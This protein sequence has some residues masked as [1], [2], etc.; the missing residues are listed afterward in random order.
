MMEKN[1]EIMMNCLRS[2]KPLS[3]FYHRAKKS[4]TDFIK[5]PII[6]KLMKLINDLSQMKKTFKKGKRR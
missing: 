2:L 5:I 3:H 4:Q 6:T 1:T